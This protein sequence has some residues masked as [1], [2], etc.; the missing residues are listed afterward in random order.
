MH[1][2]NLW[3]HSRLTSILRAVHKGLGQFT[4]TH[5]RPAGSY[6]ASPSL[7][8]LP[9]A[10]HSSAALHTKQGISSTNTQ[11]WENTMFSA[12]FLH[13]LQESNRTARVTWNHERSR[14]GS[15]LKSPQT[16]AALGSDQA[17]TSRLHFPVSLCEDRSRRVDWWKQ[18][19]E[20][21]F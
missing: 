17:E 6:R 2:T 16:P 12:L 13:T 19:K 5:D 7:F 4:C 9:R 14:Q 15:S 10:L 18:S 8:W 20:S 1:L 11:D 3:R 21:V